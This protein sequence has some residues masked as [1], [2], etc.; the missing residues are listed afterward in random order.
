M[1]TVAQYE[2]KM[3]EGKVTN[4]QF[5]LTIRTLFAA[6]CLHFFMNPKSAQFK[7]LIMTPHN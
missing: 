7:H 4:F 3:A 2:Q 5:K 6:L 1:I